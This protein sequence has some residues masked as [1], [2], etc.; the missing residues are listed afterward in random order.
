MPRISE[1]QHNAME[2][3]ANGE[4]TLDIPKEVEEEFVNADS[5]DVIDAPRNELD[6]ARKIQDGHLS[7]PQKFG[8][9]WL[10]DIRITGTG[11][12]YRSKDD[13]FVF[14][15]PEHYMNDE[16]LAR[17]NGLQVIWEHPD[18][19]TLNTKEFRSRS[20]G[21]IFLP[22]LKQEEKEVWGIA[23]IYDEDAIKEIIENKLSTSPTVV[24]RKIDGNS[25]I[26]LDNGHEVMVE[27]NPSLLDH[28]AICSLGVWDKGGDPSGVV[29]D[30]TNLG[31][32]KMDEKLNE[33]VDAETAKADDNLTARF[34]AMMS[35]VDSLNKKVDAFMEQGK[36][37]E[38]AA[39]KKAD[40]ED[41]EK[42]E[43]AEDEKDM[44]AKA[45][46]EEI[47]KR[48]DAV[49]KLMPK[50]VADADYEAMADCQAKADS[51]ATS[52][53]ESAS[54][55]QLGETVLGYRKRQAAKFKKHSPQYKDV[56]ISS[57]NDDKLFGI[58]E[59]QIYADAVQAANNPIVPLEEGLR[60]IK[61]KTDAGHTIITY[62]GNISSWLNNFKAD[63]FKMDGLNLGAK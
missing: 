30:S 56:D 32:V 10:V 33:K 11:T 36:P 40:A 49:E 28:V 59:K 55:P 37:K 60:A 43:K 42:K 50:E 21:S 3:A 39:D 62:K 44:K 14:R 25:I 23:K 31:V 8:N 1:K 51:I 18:K 16:F 2:A 5:D 38:V 17:C 34:D 12:S 27:G 58:V 63:S 61:T 52:F 13:E 7:S 41:E 35:A 20:I 45:D 46:A 26:K 24:F 15:P 54:R 9:V 6:V 53:G 22:Y 48:I 19:G 47:K 4:S 29:S 57:I